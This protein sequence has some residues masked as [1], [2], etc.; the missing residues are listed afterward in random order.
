MKKFLIFIIISSIFCQSYQNPI[1]DITNIVKCLLKSDLFKTGFEKIKVAIE[2][3]DISNIIN[4]G[5]Y[6]FNEFKYEINHCSNKGLRKLSNQ[7]YE[8]VQLRYPRAVQ[9]LYTQIGE[10]AFKWYD[11]GGIPYL[12]EEC[13]R[14]KGRLIW[15]CQYLEEAE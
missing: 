13:H 14:Q 8:D 10:D 4:T 1:E 7:A 11:Q 6:L 12:K 9:V 3:K 2:S 5:I 15:Y